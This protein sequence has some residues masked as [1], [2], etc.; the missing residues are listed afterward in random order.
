MSENWN[1]FTSPNIGLLINRSVYQQPDVLEALK[2]DDKEREL[3]FNISKDVKSTP[4][5]PL[6]EACYAQTA[7]NLVQIKNPLAN[8]TFRLYTTY[9]GLLCG[10]G[11]THDTGSTGD[12]KIGFFF[13]HTTGQPIIPGSSVKGVLRQFFELDRDKDDRKLTHNVTLEFFLQWVLN[14]K[15]NPGTTGLTK[16]Q[17]ST[18][19]DKLTEEKLSELKLEIFGHQEQGGKDR[20]FDAVIDKEKTGSKKYLSN[21]FITPHKSKGDNRE[22]DPFSNP[23][24]LM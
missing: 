7:D 9:P 24:P 8:E 17:L 3:K 20:F 21:D 6:Y 15:L 16:E 18:M 12:F 5:D 11:Y 14:D 13:D 19:A 10:S 1:L 22:L 23:T 2:Y 4:F